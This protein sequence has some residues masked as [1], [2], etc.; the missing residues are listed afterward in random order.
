MVKQ[1]LVILFLLIS[2]TCYSEIK[3]TITDIHVILP[4]AIFATKY[5]TISFNKTFENSFD[6]F[7]CEIQPIQSNYD[8]TNSDDFLMPDKIIY[9][10]NVIGNKQTYSLIS[11]KLGTSYIACLNKSDYKLKSDTFAEKRPIHLIENSSIIQIVIR[12]NNSYLGYLTELINIPF[13]LPPVNIIEFGH[14][15]DLRIGSDC[16][17]LAIYGKRRQGYKI[18]YCGPY[19][20]VDFLDELEKDKLFEGCIVHFGSQV[21]VLYQDNGVKNVLDK[22]DILIQSYLSKVCF[23]SYL[24]SGFYNKDYN[25]YK[26]KYKYVN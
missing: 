3:V 7:W 24:N 8:K 4:K 13:V 26:W 17:E 6:Y 12:Q 14:Q 25:I 18:P 15:T 2:Y 9:K 10:I 1:R 16:A 11:S 19:R 23:V 20:I 5:D 21:S 22:D